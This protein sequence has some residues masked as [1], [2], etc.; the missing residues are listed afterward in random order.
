[1]KNINTYF[2]IAFFIFIADTLSA[3]NFSESAFAKRREL[4][5]QEVRT[6]VAI[7]PSTMKDGRLNKN[8]Y[9][10]TGI[11]QPGYIYAFDMQER[12]ANGKLFAPEQVNELEAFI[13]QTKTD[14]KRLILSAFSSDFNQK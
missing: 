9:Y 8:F 7:I 10:L 6:G 11:D 5:A 4:F 14:K 12:G 1:M 13:E 2:C 3:Q